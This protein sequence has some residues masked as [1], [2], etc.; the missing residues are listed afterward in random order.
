MAALVA[1]V[2]ASV[3]MSATAVAGA[4]KDKPEVTAITVRPIHKAQVVRGDDGKT[5]SNTICS[6]SVWSATR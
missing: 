6:S 5:T 4:G 3:A 1:A 2:A